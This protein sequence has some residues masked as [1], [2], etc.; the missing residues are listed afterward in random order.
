MQPDKMNFHEVYVFNIPEYSLSDIYDVLPENVFSIIH[1][2]NKVILKPNWIRES[3][4]SRASEWEQ[5]ITHPSVITAVLKKV[6]EKLEGKGRIS[7]VDGPETASSFEKILLHY[8]VHLWKNMAREAGITLGI[9]DLRE[10]EWISDGTVIIERRK[11]KGDPLGSTQI[12]LLSDASEFNSHS[13]Q[14]GYFGADSNILETNRAHNGTDNLYRVSRTVLEADVFINLPKLK[15]HKKA[16]ITASLKNLVG[17]NTYKNFLPHNSI[18]TIKDG[19]DQFPVKTSK[20]TIESFLMP[21]I[22]QKIL[23]KPRLAKMFR[24]LM[25]LGKYMFGNNS[26]IIRGGSWY[27]NDTLWRTILDLNKVLFYANPDGSMSEDNLSNV[28]KY[29]T[30][31]DGI[32][33]GEGDGPKSPDCVNLGYLFCGTNPVATDAVCATFMGFDPLKIPAIAN[34]FLVKRYSLT[35]FSFDLIVAKFRDENLKLK[36]ISPQ[37]IKYFRPQKGWI[38]HIEIIKA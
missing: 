13:P 21:A 16:G 37:F 31:V 19:G 20:S 28:K 30:V 24:P 12:N 9:V 35:Y 18:G 4:L 22:H 25:S 3:H 32:L 23:G 1:P 10:D 33:A 15:T 34:A 29:I 11:L 2:G 8:P 6:L 27:G 7:I 5:V 14:N 36:E 26:Q 38:G 17:I